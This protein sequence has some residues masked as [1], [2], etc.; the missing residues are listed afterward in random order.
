M[1]RRSKWLVA[2]WLF[3]LANLGGAFVALRMN[4]PAE[5]VGLHLVLLVIGVYFIR[6]LGRRPDGQP[7]P[8]GAPLVDD[9]LERIEQSM[10]TIA[11]EVERMG[12]AQRFITKLAAERAEIPRGPKT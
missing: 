6:R 11:I 8:G 9:R 2:A 3:T 7:V 5:H 10:D 4:E 12:E 1:T